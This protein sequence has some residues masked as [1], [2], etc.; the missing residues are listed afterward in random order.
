[1]SSELWDRIGEE[2]FLNPYFYLVFI[3]VVL[4]E[5]FIPAIQGQKILSNG[6]LVD[7]CWVFIN[8]TFKV[9]V[10]TLLY[11]FL[12]GFYDQYLSFLSIHLFD[13]Y[14]KGFKV[15]FALLLGDFV[16]W[17]GHYVRH[18]VK[19]FWYFHEVHHSQK[20][21]NFFSEYRVH[22]IDDLFIYFIHFIPLLMFIESF[23]TIL[24]IQWLR[25][26]HSRIYHSNIK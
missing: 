18:K 24:A 10:F 26:W 1:M 13:H 21:L 6:F 22:P 16:Y 4:A 5:S 8:L 9:L 19:L 7:F 3:A 12:R 2:V 17:F 23:T 11:K 25:H 14:S 20:Q 15:C